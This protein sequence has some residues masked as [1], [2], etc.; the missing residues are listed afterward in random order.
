MKVSAVFIPIASRP[1]RVLTLTPGDGDAGVLWPEMWVG[2]LE[3]AIV[4]V[5]IVA[6]QEQ[7]RRLDLD[8][9]KAVLLDAGAHKVHA[10]TVEVEREEVVA[11]ETLDEQVDDVDAFV[12][13]LDLQNIEERDELVDLHLSYLAKAAA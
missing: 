4:K 11:G 12:R 13:W 6:T 1:L 2:E 10:I 9:V 3:G 7:A 8:A 5:K